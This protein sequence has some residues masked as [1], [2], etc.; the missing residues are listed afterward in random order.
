[1]PLATRA[2]VFMWFGTVVVVATVGASPAY[3]VAPSASFSYS[4]ASP[5][6]NEPVTFVSTASGPI[7]AQSWDLNGDRLCNDATGPSAQRAFPTSGVYAITLCV[8]GGTGSS[9]ATDMV[10]V[11]NRAPTALFSYA[12]G[13]PASGDSVVLTSYSADPDGPIV[14][15]AWDLDGDGA[16]DDGQGSTASVT[17]GKAGEYPVGLLVIDRDGATG[18][19]LHAIRVRAPAAQFISPFPVVRMVGSIGRRGTRI[20]EIVVKVPAGGRVRISCRGG[21]CPPVTKRSGGARIARTLRV[22]R[23]ARRVLRPGAVVRVWVTKS[24]AIGKY[25]RFRIRAGKP[26]VRADRCLMPGSRR[27]VRC[28]S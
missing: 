14:S 3:A 6:T 13:A 12:P 5:L 10:T 16:Y 19:A 22:R 17:F 2:S 26:P 24:G 8:T 20:K 1:M 27:P 18:V 21:G 25:T 7:S 9:T 11:R 28:G 23:F 4:P 15:Q